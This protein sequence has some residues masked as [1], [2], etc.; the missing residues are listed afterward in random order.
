MESVHVIKRPLLTEKTTFGMNELGQY[1]FEVDRRATKPQIKK[2]VE[3]LYN[4]NVVSINTQVRKGRVRR[5]R[6]G[7]VQTPEI[8]RALVRLRE[9]QVIE[10]L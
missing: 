7:Y 5:L 6:V 2:A 4:V 10:V 1:A 9:G 8:K 3:E